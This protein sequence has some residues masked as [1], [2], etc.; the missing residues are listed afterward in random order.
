[1]PLSTKDICSLLFAKKDDGRYQW[2]TYKTSTP[3]PTATPTCSIISSATT[4][5]SKQHIRNKIGGIPLIWCTSYRFNFVVKEYLKADDPVLA[6]VIALMSKLRSI[7]SALLRRSFNNPPL[8]RNDTRW[9]STF[10]MLDRYVEL[11]PYLNSLDH[12]VEYD[13]QPLYFRRSVNERV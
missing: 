5:P 7:N 11:E 4:P 13:V 10:A 2:T 6:T 1:M 12:G 8:I 3:A 9:P